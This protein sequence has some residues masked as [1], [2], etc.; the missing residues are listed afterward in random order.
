MVFH[1]LGFTIHVVCPKTFPPAAGTGLR[2]FF[3]LVFFL[4]FSCVFLVFLCVVLVVIF[5]C[6]SWVYF[7]FFSYF[8]VFF[9]IFLMLFSCFS[10]VLLWLCRGFVVVLSWFLVVFLRF[11]RGFLVV[12]LCFLL[13]F[14]VIFSRGFSRAFLPPYIL[15]IEQIKDLRWASKN[16]FNCIRWV[17]FWC[18]AN[19][20]SGGFRIIGG[21][22]AWR[23]NMKCLWRKLLALTIFFSFFPSFPFVMLLLVHVCQWIQYAQVKLN[24]KTNCIYWTFKIS[25]DWWNRTFLAMS[26]VRIGSI[27]SHNLIKCLTYMDH[28]TLI[29]V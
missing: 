6:L 8:F 10:V 13:N 5:L 28:H 12:F 22:L 27:K 9:R 26:V 24:R 23:C 19:E 15:Q 17:S 1:A 21:Q 3:F 11:R 25:E 4:C 7:K 16:I 29:A 18:W 20:D 14:L 2:R